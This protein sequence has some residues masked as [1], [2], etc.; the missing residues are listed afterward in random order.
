MAGEKNEKERSGR[1]TR[2]RGAKGRKQSGGAEGGEGE[3]ERG[4]NSRTGVFDPS[5]RLCGVLGRKRVDAT[6]AA[7]L[8]RLGF[9]SQPKRRRARG[10]SEQKKG[11]RKTEREGGRKGE[12]VRRKK[13][14][15]WAIRGQTSVASKGRSV[16]GARAERRGAE[17]PREVEGRGR[18]RPA[19]NGKPPWDDA[20]DAPSSREPGVSRREAHRSWLV[21]PPP[22]RFPA[23]GSVRELRSRWARAGAGRGEGGLERRVSVEDSSNTDQTESPRPRGRGRKKRRGKGKGKKGRQRRGGD[24]D[25]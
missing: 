14:M 3:A 17:A 11:E 8:S 2:E 5:V 18:R 1:G 7:G 6:H 23:A 13:S 19:R 16:D 12:E 4:G 24:G 9:R 25:G 10:E 15:G 20:P 21:A 22:V